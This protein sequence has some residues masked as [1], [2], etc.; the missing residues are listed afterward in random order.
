MK[1]K[2]DLVV[3]DV[4]GCLVDSLTV[5][6][7][8]VNLVRQE[9]GLAAIDS[10]AVRRCMGGSLLPF[11]SLTLSGSGSRELSPESLRAAGARYQDLFAANLAQ[12]KPFLGIPQVLSELE[13]RHIGLAVCSNKDMSLILST[14]EATG[15]LRYFPEKVLIGG[16]TFSTAKPEPEPLRYLVNLFSTTPKKV[17]MVGDSREDIL[18]AKRV[19]CRSVACTYGYGRPLVEGPD[20]VVENPRDIL[21]LLG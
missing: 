13:G 1:D 17:W 3:F 4:D 10:S 18:M 20:F 5:V 16:D 11:I 8:A 7:L 19:G 15:L 12:V 21:G 2:P 6:T 9:H 14:L